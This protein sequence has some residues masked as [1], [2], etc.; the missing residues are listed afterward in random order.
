M[1]AA[2]RRKTITRRQSINFQFGSQLKVLAFTVS[3][4]AF[5]AALLQVAWLTSAGNRPAG[6]THEGRQLRPQI[7]RTAAAE[8]EGVQAVLDFH[9]REMQ[10]NGSSCR[11]LPHS[12]PSKGRADTRLTQPDQ[13]CNQDESCIIKLE[14]VCL[15]RRDPEPP[16]WNDSSY[17]YGKP[18]LEVRGL[19]QACANQKALAELYG[20]GLCGHMGK[21]LPLGLVGDPVQ[22][23]PELGGAEISWKPQ[24]FIIYCAQE[25]CDYNFFHSIALAYYSTYIALRKLG[26]RDL[27]G[28]HVEFYECQAGKPNEV[29]TPEFIA[30][31]RDRHAVF[32]E[33]FKPASISFLDIGLQNKT[34]FFGCYESVVFVGHNEWPWHCRT[35]SAE[36]DP[37]L[38]GFANFISEALGFLGPPALPPEDHLL[39]FKRQ[40]TV[41][42]ILNTAEVEAAF[43][44]PFTAYTGAD[45]LQSYRARLTE[46]I[47]MTRG[48]SIIFGGHGA[49]LT[50]AIFA[51]QD[52]VVVEVT[53]C[54]FR[55][56]LYRNLAVLTGKF[57]LELVGGL[58]PL[59]LFPV[60]DF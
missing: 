3:L 33:A 53:N 17:E 58:D 42:T 57:Y 39:Y 54:F 43:P 24:T 47:Q 34:Q 15:T 22:A 26:L 37:M 9:H 45:P 13:T 51:P 49:G 19:G 2:K 8:I 29:K 10:V 35:T 31:A 1:Q 12:I 48:A 30:A 14:R 59:A 28:V 60:S 32:L 38:T 7:R 40:N 23:L 44:V 27:E 46:I 20:G 16:V 25:G 4:L 11:F 56:P 18:F 21:R 6:C 36:A 50:N 5:A 52:A 41:R 55:N